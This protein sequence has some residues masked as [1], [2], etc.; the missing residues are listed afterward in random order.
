[1]KSTSFCKP[2]VEIVAS[3][4]RF[5]FKC[6]VC[7]RHYVVLLPLVPRS[8]WQL[9]LS[10][11]SCFK[12]A[13]IVSHKIK[14]LYQCPFWKEL[15]KTKIGEFCLQY[16]GLLCAFS[17][18]RRVLAFLKLVMNL[19]CLFTQLLLFDQFYDGDRLL[20]ET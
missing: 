17:Q 2:E 7:K 11:D 19:K 20:S 18:R 6:A 13:W 9:S 16:M 15:W 4:T 12:F 8:I 1:M 14:M 5:G 3:L 10:I